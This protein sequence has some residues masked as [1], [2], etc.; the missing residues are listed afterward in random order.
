MRRNCAAFARAARR[1]SRFCDRSAATSGVPFDRPGDQRV[2]AERPA[3]DVAHGARLLEQR[4]E[5]DPGRRCPS[6]PASRRGPRSRCCRSR[7]PGPGSRRARRSST[8]SSRS[9]PRARRAR[10]PGPGRACCGSAPSARRRRRA[11]RAP[12]AKNARTWSGLAIP[13]VSPKPISSAPAAIS[14][15]AIANTRVR[16]DVALVGAAERRPRSRPRSAGPPSRARGSTASS[17]V[18]DSSTERLTFARLCVSVAHRKTL[19]SSNAGRS[20]SCASRSASALS[21]PRSFGIS[22][23]TATSGGTSIARSTSARVGELR[24]HVGAHEARDL[25]PPQAAAREPVD[26]ARLVGGRR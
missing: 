25:E 24:D 23:E 17:P 19:I 2:A 9:P 26:Q 10:S 8:R 4:V 11:A 15:S 14:R 22:T 7:P 18:S 12:A 3:E 21:R 6:P 16:L 13:V 20:H 1:S 5:V